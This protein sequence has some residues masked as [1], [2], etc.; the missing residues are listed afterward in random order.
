MY[1]QSTR[2]Y[3]FMDMLLFVEL[4]LNFLGGSV[5]Y[6]NTYSLSSILLEKNTP[7]N[8]ITSRLVAQIS[9]YM[10]PSTLITSTRQRTACPPES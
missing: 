1:L 10:W 7:K 3:M 8:K 4:K 6:L 5:P 2:W 9:C